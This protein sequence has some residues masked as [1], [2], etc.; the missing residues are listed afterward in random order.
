VFV[1][2]VPPHF[3]F[4]INRVSGIIGSQFLITLGEGEDMA[5]D[6]LHA[7]ALYLGHVV[8]DH[9]EVL[10]Q[11]NTLYCDKDG[12]P[13]TDVRIKRALI[14]YDP[15][16]EDPPGME[17]VLKYRGIVPIYNE[18]H[19]SNDKSSDHHQ[20]CLSPDYAKPPEERVEERIAVDDTDLLLE[21]V[22][23]DE[24]KVAEREEEMERREAKSHAVV[25]EM[26]GDLPDADVAPAENVLFVCKLNPITTDDDLTLIFS[27]FDANARATV[28][29][30]P[31]TQDSLCYA[32]VEFSSPQPCT[33][34]YF[35]MN[36]VLVD[37][38]RIK[39]DFSQSVSKEWNR[40]TQTL[41]RRRQGITASSVPADRKETYHK[42]MHPNTTANSSHHTVPYRS[43]TALHSHSTND[44]DIKEPS[45]R[46]VEGIDKES[47]SGRE[48]RR[49]KKHKR[50]TH[51]RV[52]KYDDDH[53]SRSTGSRSFVSYSSGN[54][55][56]SRHYKKQS[57]RRSS[58]DDSS[59]YG[60]HY[61]RDR[62][63]RDRHHKKDR[64][65]EGSQRK[66]S[67]KKYSS[68]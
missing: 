13:Y 52:R 4:K 22:N 48:K 57:K 39:V 56:P 53:D 1:V 42:K 62:R 38:R 55:R 3:I 8:E 2:C 18:N 45:K 10:R 68:Y 47:Q 26:L 51:D 54:E 14:V 25:L 23:D 35:K 65:R 27:R 16:E 31:I 40:Y 63:S 29:R 6:G 46:S 64:K 11:I 36:N 43:H 20:Y 44:D 7:Q 49:K 12:R 33:E 24:K 41:R 59:N 61:T 67:K 21:N 66:H 9:N 28:I 32:F 60:R 50:H 19:D 58:S 30:D 34:A 5:L 37:D 15:F 17:N